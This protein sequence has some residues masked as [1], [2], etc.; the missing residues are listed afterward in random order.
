MAL[1]VTVTVAPPIFPCSDSRNCPAAE[2]ALIAIKYS[3]FALFR[4]G[5]CEKPIV[6]R[7][8][9]GTLAQQER[10]SSKGGGVGVFHS[11]IFFDPTDKH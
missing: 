4:G 9:A 5:C 6:K 8:R 10:E 2:S 1:H 11:P 7:K 3:M